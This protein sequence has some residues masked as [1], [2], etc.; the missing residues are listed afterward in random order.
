MA[1]RLFWARGVFGV[2]FLVV[3]FLTVTPNPDDAKSGMEFARWIA[4]RLFGDDAFA[5]KVG[6]FL[7]YAALGLA[8]FWARFAPRGR[9]LW[10]PLALAVYGAALEG[11]QGLGGVRSPELADA[12]ANAAGAL[13]GFGGAFFLARFGRS[14][15]R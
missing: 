10:A 14:A 1:S 7:A 15:A 13:A 8:A 12:V 9:R 4:A 5:D 11:V 3:T 2:L 6:H